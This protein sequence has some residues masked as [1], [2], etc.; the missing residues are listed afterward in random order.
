LDWHEW[1][2]SQNAAPPEQIGSEWIGVLLVVRRAGAT[3][4]HAN[5]AG[6]GL[7]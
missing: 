3:F 1:R 6:R 2:G 7:R 4:T 5:R